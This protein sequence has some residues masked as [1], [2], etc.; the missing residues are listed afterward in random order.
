MEKS[1]KELQ[2]FNFMKLKYFDW[3]KVAVTVKGIRFTNDFPNQLSY[4]DPIDAQLTYTS[5][6]RV[7]HSIDRVNLHSFFFSIFL[8]VDKIPFVKIVVEIFL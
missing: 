5:F 2:R 4:T 8:S 1:A 3:N 6:L 7:V